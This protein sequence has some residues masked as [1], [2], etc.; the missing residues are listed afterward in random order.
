MGGIAQQ[1]N[2]PA[3]PLRQW[4]PIEQS[5]LEASLDTL[6]DDA[7]V[8]MRHREGRKQVFASTLDRPGFFNPIVRFCYRHKVEQRAAAHKVG[9]DVA[10]SGHHVLNDDIKMIRW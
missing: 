9:N 4:I 10:G 6:K 8:T 7:Q 1:C 3:P 2:A 5:P